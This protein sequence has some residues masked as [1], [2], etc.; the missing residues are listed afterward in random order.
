MGILHHR[1]MSPGQRRIFG[2]KIAVTERFAV[3]GIPSPAFKSNLIVPR[4]HP[5]HG[6]VFLAD[7]E[8]GKGFTSFPGPAQIPLGGPE[9]H[10][11]GGRC[12]SENASVQ[13]IDKSDDIRR[14]PEN[15][16]GVGYR[17]SGLKSK[18][19]HQTNNK[20]NDDFVLMSGFL[21]SGCCRPRQMIQSVPC[22][23][24]ATDRLWEPYSADASWL[25]IMD[26]NGLFLIE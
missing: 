23:C 24:K 4:A 1:Q 19:H 12:A 16:I 8:G 20:Q 18:N 5:E 26:L 22:R 17:M 13:R 3:F 21:L 14:P 10:L 2:E 11:L 9:C 25:K 15:G 6:V 7:S